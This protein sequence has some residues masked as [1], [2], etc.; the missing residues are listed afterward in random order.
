MIIR[1]LEEFIIKNPDLTFYEVLCNTGCCP[2]EYLSDVS[3]PNIGQYGFKDRRKE[4]SSITLSRINQ[5]VRIK[6]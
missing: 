1:R 3:N 4:T 5:T 6:N 2:I